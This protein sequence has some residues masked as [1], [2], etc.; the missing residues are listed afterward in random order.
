MTA[1]TGSALRTDGSSRGLPPFLPG[2][3]ICVTF[4]ASIGGAEKHN[5]SHDVDHDFVD[6]DVS[7]SHLL[8]KMQIDIGLKTIAAIERV[9]SDSACSRTPLHG[10]IVPIARTD[11]GSCYSMD[12]RLVKELSVELGAAAGGPIIAK[13]MAQFNEHIKKQKLPL[14][15]CNG[16]VNTGPMGLFID[17]G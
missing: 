4:V 2:L 6:A 1:F 7:K 16:I 15:C 14:H 8:R 13:L 9:V 10:R 17:L 5:A 3:E 11:G 12:P